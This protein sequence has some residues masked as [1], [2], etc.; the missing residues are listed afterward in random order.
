MVEW[1][2]QVNTGQVRPMVRHSVSNR[3]TALLQNIRGLHY[4]S[5]IEACQRLHA[6]YFL[7]IVSDSHLVVKNLLCFCTAS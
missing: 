4:D 7:A 5:F 1:V 6:T 2:S 3:A